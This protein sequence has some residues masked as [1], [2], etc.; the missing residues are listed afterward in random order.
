[1]KFFERKKKYHE[2]LARN[3]KPT[4]QN[5]KEHDG[6]VMEEM[7]MVMMMIKMDGT[8]PQN[9]IQPDI[10][11][12]HSTHTFTHCILYIICNQNSFCNKIFLCI[13]M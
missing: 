11:P 6:M 12:L 13:A 3:K 5:K 4:E 10:S 2:M 8:T 9:V 7:E 1:M